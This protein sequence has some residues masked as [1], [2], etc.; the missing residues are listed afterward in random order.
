MRLHYLQHV[1]FEG[2]GSIGDWADERGLQVSATRMYAGDPL[3]VANE[4]ELL[5][6]LGGPM[7]VRDRDCLPWLDA[8]IEW[9]AEAVAAERPVLGLCL[10]AQLI[11]CAAGADVYKASDREIGWFPVD[12]TTGNQAGPL[13]CLPDRLMAFHWHGDTFDIPPGGS[14]L[15]ASEGCAHQAFGIGERILGLQFHLETTMGVA[16]A[17]VRNCPED[18]SP[19]PWVQTREE[20]LHGGRFDDANR[21]MVRVLDQWVDACV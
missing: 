8:E 15:A 18:L 14:L 9:L 12:R 19:G 17:L 5:L 6:V 7:G 1:P 13:D 16:E 4:F 10:G 21:L 2:L 20:I 11:A 3:P